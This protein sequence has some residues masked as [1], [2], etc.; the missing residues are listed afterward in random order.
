MAFELDSPERESG[1]GSTTPCGVKGVVGPG[2]RAQIRLAV[3]KTEC[4]LQ[5]TTTLLPCS[6]PGPCARIPAKCPQVIVFAFTWDFWFKIPS[7]RVGAFVCEAPTHMMRFR[8]ELAAPFV[9][10]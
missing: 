2:S 10:G 7:T 4:P 9:V 6:L 1:E 3:E 8:R 5:R